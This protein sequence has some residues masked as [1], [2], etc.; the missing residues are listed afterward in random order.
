MT[1][2]EMAEK[3]IQKTYGEN[4]MDTNDEIVTK[5]NK[6]MFDYTTGAKDM[7]KKACEYLEPVFKNY[8]GYN[9]GADVL[10]LFENAM[11]N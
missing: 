7:L 6:A 9:C 3:H 10:A 2:D 1:I 11:K 4:W 5:A 8:A